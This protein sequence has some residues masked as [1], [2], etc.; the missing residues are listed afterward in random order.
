MPARSFQAVVGTALTDNTF[1]K[2]LLNGSR[3]RVLQ[4]FDLTGEEVEA[5]MGIR[6]DSLDEFA[7]ALH[8][9]LLQSQGQ[10][11]LTPLPILMGRQ[12]RVFSRPSEI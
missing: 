5:I 11:E 8:T 1:R 10:R 4:S 7:G 3:R 6:A 12:G 2:D 9:L